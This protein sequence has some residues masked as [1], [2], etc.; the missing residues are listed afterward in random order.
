[1][2]GRGI[3]ARSNIPVFPMYLLLLYS[4]IL[5]L[6]PILIAFKFTI[7]HLQYMT[8]FPLTNPTLI[9]SL[10]VLTGMSS[11]SLEAGL[12]LAPTLGTRQRLKPSLAASFTRLSS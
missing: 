2:A 1:M 12:T 4:I 3:C 5:T 11:M 9:A 8:Y 10:K 7:L 6:S